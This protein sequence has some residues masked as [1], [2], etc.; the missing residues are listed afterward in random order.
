MIAE[1]R[2]LYGET[3][4]LFFMSHSE[5]DTKII[6]YP[7]RYW[8][9]FERKRNFIPSELLIANICIKVVRLYY[10]VA[11]E[12]PSLYDSISWGPTNVLT[13]V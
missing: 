6:N 10:G 1:E 5:L 12:T 2:D 7:S 8:S 3:S 4:C 9:R 11:G 13:L